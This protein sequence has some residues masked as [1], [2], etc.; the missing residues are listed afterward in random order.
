[1][2]KD[3]KSLSPEE[4]AK[5]DLLRSKT[6]GSPAV[7]ASK[8]V[9][10]NGEQYEIRAPSMKLQ[11]KIERLSSTKDGV[12]NLKALFVALINC[13]FIP[14]TDILVFEEADEMAMGERGTKDFVGVFSKALTDL[15][16]EVNFESVEK[17]S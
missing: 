7:H 1:M 13:I 10:W 3:V 2:A 6:L 11:Q 12:D 16:R 17:N 15:A 9:E 8:T 5:R 14:E 4:K